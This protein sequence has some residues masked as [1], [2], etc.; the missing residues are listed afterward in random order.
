M[1]RKKLLLTTLVLAGLLVLGQ[2]LSYWF[3]L[4]AE[5]G[6]Q[7]ISLLHRLSMS[8]PLLLYAAEQFARTGD[9]RFAGDLRKEVALSDSLFRIAAVRSPALGSLRPALDTLRARA[10]ALLEGVPFRRLPRKEFQER[11]QHL[12]E[13]SAPVMERLSQVVN[14]EIAQLRK[15]ADRQKSLSFIFM[16]MSLFVFLLFPYFLSRWI[17]SPLTTLRESLFRISLGDLDTEVYPPE[18]DEDLTPVYETIETLRKNLK[19][20]QQRIRKLHRGN[21]PGH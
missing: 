21:A 7:R 18:P 16:L 11:Y 8:P 9:P 6:V 12:L 19:E 5:Q 15:Q 10:E 3:S 20:A 4:R 17:L 13:A 2:G 1:M 14:E